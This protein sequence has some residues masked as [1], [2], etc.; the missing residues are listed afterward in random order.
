LIEA[1][2]KVHRIIGDVPS[3]PL[4]ELK[5]KQWK[6]GLVIRSPNWL[7]DAVMTLPSMMQLRKIIPENCGMFVVCPP[8]L[9]YFFESMDIVDYTLALEQAHKFMNKDEWKT[10]RGLQAGL[11]VHYSNSLRDAISFK[12]AGIPRMFGGSARG[13]SMLFTRTWKYPKRKNK[14]LNNFH[15]AA[16][17]LSMAYALGAPEWTGELPVFKIQKEL[18]EMA[19][20][21]QQTLKSEKLLLMAAGAAYGESKRW[22]ANNFTK[23]SEY[24]LDS[25]GT[26]AMLGTGKE[27]EI[28][29]E[30]IK[31][32][33][34]EK[35]VNLAGAT[36]LQ[37]LMLLIQ[38]ASLCIANDSGVMHL[39]AALG[40]KGI[41]IFGSTDP[42]ATSPIT[43]GWKIMF[44]KQE[45]A[46]C[47]TRQCP[48]PENK[49]KCLK[50]ITPEKVIEAIN[51]FEL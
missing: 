29:D 28:G 27:K 20:P 25:G 36:D 4:Y 21:V 43:D 33:P 7:G 24:W 38:N 51:S 15:H 39:A 22:P 50:A 48:L 30:V 40:C 1:K 16:K 31:G 45:C 32:L 44:E 14:E 5:L 26:I 18:N 3:F 47:F 19:E 35:A 17:Y 46:P 23:V 6:D 37:E 9:K 11:A 10:L 34:P 2:E 12:M 42:T 8:S 41:A 13:R 49:Y